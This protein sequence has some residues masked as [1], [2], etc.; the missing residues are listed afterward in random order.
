MSQ[1]LSKVTRAATFN[2]CCRDEPLALDS[3]FLHFVRE[4]AHRPKTDSAA[5][6]L[7]ELIAGNKNIEPWFDADAGLMGILTPDETRTLAADLRPLFRRGS[8]GSRAG[9]KRRRGGLLGIIRGFLR[10]LFAS[11]PSEEEILSLFGDLLKDAVRESHG[12]A[13]GR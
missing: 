11:P 6:L 1:R 12:L 9:R 3:T 13:L 2:E 4:L 10:G 7:S 5:V 8:F